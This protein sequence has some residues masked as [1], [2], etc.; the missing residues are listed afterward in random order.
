[1][2]DEQEKTPVIFLL[3][4]DEHQSQ[5]LSNILQVRERGATTIVLTNLSNI[6]ALIDLDKIDFLIELTPVKS[7]LA[8]ILACAP[9]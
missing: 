4:D 3:L 5:I 6:D 1:M 7:V 9:L 8:A 2:I